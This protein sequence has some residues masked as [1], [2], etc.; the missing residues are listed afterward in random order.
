VLL[1]LLLKVL[2]ENILALIK[3]FDYRG[4]PLPIVRNMARQMLI[5]LDYLHRCYCGVSE[6]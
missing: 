1:F 2:G 5:G 6:T 4:I 3:R